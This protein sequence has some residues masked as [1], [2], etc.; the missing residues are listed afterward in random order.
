MA[1]QLIYVE[2]RPDGRHK[3][4]APRT[5][6]DHLDRYFLH[7]RI[8]IAAAQYRPRCHQWRIAVVRH[9]FAGIEII[10]SNVQSTARSAEMSRFGQWRVRWTE[11][12]VGSGN[13]GMTSIG[14]MK[15][16]FMTLVS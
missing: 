3:A 14:F 10:A 8:M 2:V 1:F 12:L 5:V 9:Y 15:I 16:V 7:I 4:P 11:L 6:D 13:N